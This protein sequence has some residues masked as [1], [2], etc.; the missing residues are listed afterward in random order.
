MV[1]FLCHTVISKNHKS[2]YIVHLFNDLLDKFFRVKKFPF[3][4]WATWVVVMSRV[5][6]T[7]DMSN[8]DFKLATI[9]KSFIN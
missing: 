6:H 7:G 1:S 5:V 8:Y 3:K 9:V 4:F 2:S